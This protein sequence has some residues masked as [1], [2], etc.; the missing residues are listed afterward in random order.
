M[1]LIKLI[2]FLVSL[3]FV[4]IALTVGYFIGTGIVKLDVVITMVII[5]FAFY[6]AFTYWYNQVFE[7]RDWI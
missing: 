2:L 5:G 3:I 1:D 7:E 4:V 6:L